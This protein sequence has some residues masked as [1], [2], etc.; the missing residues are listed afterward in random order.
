MFWDKEWVTC[1]SYRDFAPP[2]DI[3]IEIIFN[4]NKKD[5]KYDSDLRQ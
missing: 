1:V 2:V 3:V 4:I 5:K